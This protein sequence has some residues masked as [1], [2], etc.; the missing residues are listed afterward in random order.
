MLG[1]A[2]RADALV[3]AGP[4]LGRRAA[5]AAEAVVGVPGE[6]RRALRQRAERLRVEQALHVD[7][8][9]VDRLDRLR[10]R[11]GID[12][13]PE[14]RARGPC[15]DWPSSTALSNAAPSGGC[16]GDAE[17]GVEAAVTRLEQDAS[18]A[19]Q[20]QPGSRSASAFSTRIVAALFRL[21]VDA[22]CRRSRRT[23]WARASG[24]SKSANV[25]GVR[26][27]VEGSRRYSAAWICWQ[28]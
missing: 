1:A 17:I 28:N 19:H 27:K 10:Q 3:A 9:V 22:C 18:A 15:A 16:L 4:H 6:Q 24:A 2:V 14:R 11:F 12:A 25:I 23:G 26:L 20:H 8:A 7:R 21:P 13:R 5:F